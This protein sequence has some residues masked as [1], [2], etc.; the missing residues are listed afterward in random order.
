MYKEV[1][2]R[3]LQIRILQ[4]YTRETLSKMASITPKFLYEIETG[5]RGFSAAVLYNICK[6]LKVD[7]DYILMG[8]KPTEQDEKLLEVMQLFDE[9]QMDSIQAILRYIQES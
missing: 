3:I 8:E 4:G 5:R 1:G 2:E 6:A 7:S 9:S